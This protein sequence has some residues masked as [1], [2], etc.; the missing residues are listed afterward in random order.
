MNEEYEKIIKDFFEDLASRQEPL[1]E[2]FDKI[3]N[4][5]MWEL[6]VE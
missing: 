6:Y 4:D 1:G 2:E 5:N 3:L